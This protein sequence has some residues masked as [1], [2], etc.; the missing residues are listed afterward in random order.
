MDIK[1]LKIVKSLLFQFVFF[2]YTL[3]KMHFLQI[4]WDFHK[5]FCCCKKKGTDFLCKINIINFI[6]DNKKNVIFVE[7]YQTGRFV[8]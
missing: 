7:K 4:F 3:L 5:H 8:V 1:C 6:F 2:K